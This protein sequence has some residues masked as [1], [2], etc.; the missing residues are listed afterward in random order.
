MK[1]TFMKLCA[2]LVVLSLA[3][4]CSSCGIARVGMDLLQEKLYE[5]EQEQNA[6]S[7][8]E[9]LSYFTIVELNSENIGEYM[10]YV[11]N[12]YDEEGSTLT[13]YSLKEG[14]WPCIEDEDGR[15]VTGTV[16]YR[17]KT[18]FFDNQ[19]TEDCSKEIDLRGDSYMEHSVFD[20]FS[21]DG[22]IPSNKHEVLSVSFEGVKGRIFKAEIPEEKWI[23]DSFYPYLMVKRSDGEGYHHVS[24][25]SD[26]SLNRNL[27]E[28]LRQILDGA[29]A[30]E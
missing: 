22:D 4:S 26:D 8:E 16:H 2:L 10:T 6:I 12:V 27:A 20:Y 24:D 17:L 30:K 23:R 5:M 3:L 29:P 7:E 28:L 13:S 11:D 19:W 18:Y 14:W 21:V 9:F 15:G 25:Y 1:K